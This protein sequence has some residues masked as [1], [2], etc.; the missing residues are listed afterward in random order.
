MKTM[1]LACAFAGA[2]AL[3]GCLTGTKPTTT[4]EETNE[5]RIYLLGTCP[6]ESR[7]VARSAAVAD[8]RAALERFD[9]FQNLQASIRG[10]EDSLKRSNVDEKLFLPPIKDTVDE[11]RREAA[12]DLASIVASSAFSVLANAAS[13][14]RARGAGFALIATNSALAAAEKS[15][16]DARRR[17]TPP[18]TDVERA[19]LEKAVE[20]SN[21]A[22]ENSI[23]A[24]RR[25][26]PRGEGEMD[27]KMLPAL[28]LG[29]A[30]ASA[31]IPAL[32]EVSMEFLAS[33]VREAAKDKIASA[34]AIST[35]YLH[36]FPAMP[37]DD[38]TA[39]PDPSLVVNPQFGCLVVVRGTFKKIVDHDRL[40]AEV[41][42]D[43]SAFLT[44][45]GIAGSTSASKTPDFYLA[46]RIEFSGENSAFRL[47]PIDMELNNYIGNQNAEMILNVT[48]ASARA[49]RDGTPLAIATL[50][51]PR[52]ELGTQVNSALLA[53]SASGWIGFP[54]GDPV[55]KAALGELQKAY[56]AIEAA[57]R[58]G[59][60]ATRFNNCA[61]TRTELAKVGGT[62]DNVLNL[63]LPD[64][65]T[66]VSIEPQ[67]SVFV[68]A[69]QRAALDAIALRPGNRSDATD[70][71]APVLAARI[72]LSEVAE[73]ARRDV[74]AAAKAE[75]LTATY[76]G[77]LRERRSFTPVT[78][79][80]EII[81]TRKASEFMK[82][83]ADVLDKSKKGV[84][85]ALVASLSPAERAKRRADEEQ[86]T[87]TNRAAV[88]T[89]QDAV[90]LRQA[91]LDDLPA[92]AP[93][94]ERVRAE[95]NLRQA[96]IAANNAYLADGRGIPYPEAQ[97]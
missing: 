65:K 13:A 56:D 97:P 4:N 5:S 62:V 39:L 23:T 11:A 79:E 64:G 14:E 91:E 40:A 35:G 10:L 42:P 1:K 22:V 36:G 61:V 45:V 53:G 27:V 8:Y 69:F 68:L 76:R 46:A 34:T 18:L 50:P 74:A 59:R 17:A 2:V 95:N 6:G 90:R 31:V 37:A 47:V 19:E 57:G 75:E 44:A 20:N 93:R 29:A 85:D 21:L 83:L 49:G 80:A 12:S 82:V 15:L 28:A 38:P 7:P 78:I 81:E 92:T 96:K 60:Q 86:Q 58:A 88:A 84:G 41:F 25:A 51:L 9:R 54:G 48:F 66:A 55:A 24:L 71:Q 67:C 70:K 43:R 63:T 77:I 16:A 72:A 73:S 3:G 32:V 33:A 52:L 87:R 94:A 89:A 30:V 26:L